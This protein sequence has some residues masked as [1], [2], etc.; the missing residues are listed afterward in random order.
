MVVYLQCCIPVYSKVIQLYI[1]FLILVHYGL[2]QDI[3]YGSLCFTIGPHCLSTT[4]LCII[5]CIC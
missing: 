4:R 2:S 1:I 5:G 3:E